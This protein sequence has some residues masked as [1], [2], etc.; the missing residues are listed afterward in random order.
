M[1]GVCFFG[2]FA[3][4]YPRSEVLRKGLEKLGVAV[5]YCRVSHKRKILRRYAGL[6]GRFTSME[7]NFEVMLVPE[8]RHKDVPLAAFLARLN[9][10][11]CVFDPLVSRYDTK[12]ADRGDARDGTFQSWHNRNLDR[13]SMRLADLVLADTQPHADYYR[14]EFLGDKKHVAVLPVGY[15]EDL[16]SPVRPT[17]GDADPGKVAT[18][19]FYGSYL[20]LHGVETIVRAARRLA[21]EPRVEFVLVGGGQ[22]FPEVE[23]YV[24]EHGLAN[25]RLHGRVPVTDLPGIIARSTVCLGIFG[26]TAKAGRVVPNKVYQCLGMGKAVITQR[27][28]AVESLF[29]DGRDLV[30]VPAGDAER[31]A[32]TVKDLVNNEAKRERI[33]Q[34][35]ERL[36]RETYTSRHIAAMFTDICESAAAAGK[37]W[38]RGG[39]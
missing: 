16:F 9:G 5:P 21:D 38:K 1:K 34:H 28:P 18:V 27:S 17:G 24:R 23:N 8:F 14:E 39:R 19:L 6:L 20:P 15:D 7:K 25:V 36:V 2:G 10:K 35:G 31:L 4:G 3:Q 13:M 33:A 12:I 11:L 30:L 26:R 22:T 29:E 37:R 32:E